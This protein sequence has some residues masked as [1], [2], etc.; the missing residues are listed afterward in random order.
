MSDGTFVSIQYLNQRFHLKTNV[1]KYNCLKDAIPSLW[2]KTLH[3]ENA[4][5][6]EEVALDIPLIRLSDSLKK[7][8]TKV[9]NKEVYNL[10]NSKYTTEPKCKSRWE[11]VLGIKELD[12]KGIFKH[13]MFGT[14]TKLQ[15]V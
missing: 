2:R 14:D 11:D 1:L 8:V 4:V 13:V 3:E 10:F 6:A 15:K 5:I 9:T 12:W 7:P